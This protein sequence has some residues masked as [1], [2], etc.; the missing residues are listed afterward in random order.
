MGSGCGNLIVEWILR[1]P[2]NSPSRWHLTQG[3]L[4]CSRPTIHDLPLNVK[5][6]LLIFPKKSAPICH[7]QQKPR[8]LAKIRPSLYKTCRTFPALPG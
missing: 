8:P 2:G 1:P 7:K 3:F 5:P 6:N 4:L